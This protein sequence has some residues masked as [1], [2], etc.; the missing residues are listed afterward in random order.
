MSAAELRLLMEQAK[1]FAQREAY[2]LALEI[3][4]YKNT[5]ILRDGK[6]RQLARLLKT[7]A[8]DS[9]L[10]MAETVA[11]EAILLE[12]IEHEQKIIR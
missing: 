1:R 4:D 5:G 8:P 11:T 7:I 10:S 12:F 6:L 2:T 9:G 3:L